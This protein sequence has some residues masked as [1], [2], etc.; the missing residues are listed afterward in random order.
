M[1]KTDNGELPAQA[2]IDLEKLEKGEDENRLLEIWNKLMAEVKKTGEYKPDSTYGLYQIFVEIDVKD[3]PPTDAAG[4]TLWKNVEVHS[5]LKELKNHV[6]EY[7]N[8]HLVPVLFE[9][10]FIK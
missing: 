10:E 9:Y 8:K 2:S 5:L 6:K 4:N 1:I 3:N 7:Y